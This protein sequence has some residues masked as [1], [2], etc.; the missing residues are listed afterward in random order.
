MQ[1]RVRQVAPN[2]LH[3]HCHA[4]ILNLVLVDCVKNN[5]FASEFFSLLQ[6]LY[7]LLSTSEAHV[8]FIDKQKELYPGK[9]TKELKWLSDT[10]WPCRS[11]TLDVIAETYDCIIATLKHI[12]GDTDKAKAIEAAALLHQIHSFKFLACLII[13]QRVMNITKSLSD[14]LQSRTADSVYAA[15]L[16]SSTTHTLRDFRSDN[17]WDH[18][19]KYICDHTYK[20]ICDVASLNGIEEGTIDSRRRKQPR[21]LDDS[22]TFESSGRRDSLS[23]GQ[24][25]KLNIYFP[26]L[27]HLLSEFDHRFSTSNLDNMKSLDGCNSLS[28]KFLDT[29]LLSSL[30]LRYNLNHELLPNQCLLAK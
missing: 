17:V 3:V 1:Q 19:Y 14:Q 10:R 13:F 29:V 8:V 27:D 2:A 16:V 9:P 23:C 5:S 6:S 24:S 28:C 26:V 11:L 30:A 12:T 20:Y 15:G 4:H 7:V 22:I 18:T 21:T 25:I